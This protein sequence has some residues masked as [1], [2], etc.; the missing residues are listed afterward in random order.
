MKCISW[1]TSVFLQVFL[2]L[3]TPLALR[4]AT[5]PELTPE[6]IRAALPE[7]EKLA[8]KAVKDSGVPGLAVA[9]VYRDQ[10]VYLKGFG[11]RKA[12]KSE[13]VDADTIFQIASMSKPIA[14]TVLAGLVGEKLISWD[15]RIID[16]DPG[17]RM[18]DPWVT[19]NVTLRDMFAHR[20]GLPAFAG[21]PLQELGYDRTEILRRLRFLKTGDHFRS[22]YAY[23]NFGLTEAAIAAARTTGKPWEKLIE[24]KLYKPLGMK[25][26]SS[27][28]ADVEAARNRAY[29]HVCIDGK[30][31][32]K[33][34]QDDDAQSPAGGVSSSA[35]DLAQWMRLQLGNGKFEGRQIIDADALAETHRPMIVSKPPANPSKDRATCYG[36]GW[37][38]G[39]DDRGRVQL[40][41][42]G[43]FS[44]GAATTV[45]LIPSE[46]LGIT[47]LSNGFAV[48]LP[49]AL[50]RSFIELALDG[51]IEKDWFAVNKQSVEAALKAMLGSGPDLSK[52]PPQPFP[53]LP[54]DAYVGSY[55]NE[56]FGD[57]RIS[58][59]EGKLFVQLGPRKTS[60]PLNHHDRD[61]FTY[62]TE[63]DSD[64]RPNGVTFLIGPDRKAASAAIGEP[65]AEGQNTFIRVPD[66]K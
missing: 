38:V 49:E 2:T 1:R 14:S 28:Y 25:S 17:F 64:G 26:T 34:K 19:Q 24:E 48:G 11:V 54:A 16:L 53:S 40:N 9:V 4:A 46:E 29:L 39:S 57:M 7:M 44:S 22:H 59:R 10:V 63:E 65:D 58:A 55:R 41:H 61:I 6:K 23:T 30:W 5:G 56:F 35:R 18:N 8:I 43:A 50:A 60:L 31:A 27:R 13:T 52:P 62:L 3:L 51:K 45:V 33:L 37:V 32:A 47:V 12:G 15:D 20:S 21:D 66:G 36:L 42:S